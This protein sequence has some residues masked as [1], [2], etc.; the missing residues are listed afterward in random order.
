MES[1]IKQAL[2]PSTKSQVLLRARAAF[3]ASVSD[4]VRN[5]HDLTFL[6]ITKAVARRVEVVTTYRNGF[7]KNTKLAVDFNKKFG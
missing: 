5:A 1:I 6:N 2:A 4:V 7:N 3:L